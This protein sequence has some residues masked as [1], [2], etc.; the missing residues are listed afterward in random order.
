MREEKPNQEKHS[1]RADCVVGIEQGGSLGPRRGSPASLE[2][3][4][5][6]QTH[7][8]LIEYLVGRV[9]TVLSLR[10]TA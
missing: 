8:V 3:M 7:C 10:V 1:S 4:F 2:R 5:W 9:T 6:W